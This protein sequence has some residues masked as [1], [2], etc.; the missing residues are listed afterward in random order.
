M[1][2]DIARSPYCKAILAVDDDQPDPPGGR[3]PVLAGVPAQG[4]HPI[5]DG[6]SSVVSVSVKGSVAAP[7]TGLGGSY[8]GRGHGPRS[9]SPDLG[10][11]RG[12]APARLGFQAGLRTGIA[13][14]WMVA[15]IFAAAR[16]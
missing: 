13:S 7:P 1:I 15:S 11:S 9:W 16:K 3:H 12:Q 5:H 6:H 2:R 4:H 14:F 8:S 10:D